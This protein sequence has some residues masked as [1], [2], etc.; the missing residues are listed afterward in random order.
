MKFMLETFPIL[1]H[2]QF[3][4]CT[5]NERET[6]MNYNNLAQHTNFLT[7]CNIHEQY[8]LTD[9]RT[10]FHLGPRRLVSLL[11]PESECLMRWRSN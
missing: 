7:I 4:I 9:H 2:F 5:S 10:F 11:V 8:D 6:K 1:I 3:Y